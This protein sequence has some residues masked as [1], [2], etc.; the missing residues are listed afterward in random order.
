MGIERLVALFA[1]SGGEAPA[2]NAD[3]YLVAAGE[4]ALQ[5][6]FAV[7]EQLRDG[8]PGIRVELNFG[9]GSFKS[10]MK[11]AN[12]SGAE[13]ALILGEQELADGTVGIKPMRTR[14]EQS[15]GHWTNW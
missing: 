8:I 15:S 9:A 5:Q 1:A 6:A 12:N 3:V 14:D 4:G 7:A 2:S 10:Q 11:R 13:Y